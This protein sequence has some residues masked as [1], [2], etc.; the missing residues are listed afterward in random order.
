MPVLR[1][2]TTRRLGRAL[3]T[4]G[5]DESGSMII[6]SM[7]LLL[8]MLILG[9]MAVDLMRYESTRARLQATLD[10]SV[11]A[12]ADLDQT[13]DPEDVVRDYFRTAG[14]LDSLRSINVVESMNSRTVSATATVALNTFFLRNLGLDELVAP[15]VGT[16]EETVSNIEISLVLDISGS[17]RDNNRMN[18]LRPAARN[19]IS[20]VL[21]GA[22]EDLLTIN[23]VPYAGSTNPGPVMFSYLN[24]VRYAASTLPDGTAF[25]N[26]S[27]CLDLPTS[28]FNNVN[29]PSAGLAQV[30]HFMNWTIAANVM[31]WGWC[32]SDSTAIQY[33]SNNESGLHSFINSMRMH[34]GTGTHYAMK[35]AVALLNPTSRPAF[36]YLASQGVIDGAMTDA[37]TLGAFKLA[38]VTKFITTGME[39]TFSSFF[40]IMNREGLEAVINHQVKLGADL[41]IAVGPMGTGAEASTTTNLGADIISYSKA[42]GL[43][44]GIAFEG[45]VV[46]S[47]DTFAA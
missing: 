30:P 21:D 36:A 41:S 29:L 13:L 15:A 5:R 32:P 12:A 6:F 11:L 18:N 47:R 2:L 25:P 31:D 35:W 10:R 16:A 44:G 38:E 22:E 37:T 1:H 26:V 45:A 33:A 40:L 27:S 14:L 39:T 4:F 46:G 9:G 34:D 3:R 19:F 23:L 28:T 43:F 20:T 42:V 24:G 17:M 8:G 7:Y